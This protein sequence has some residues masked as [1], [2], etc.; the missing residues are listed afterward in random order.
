MIPEDLEPYRAEDIAR[1]LGCSKRTVYRA[2]QD[3]EIPGAFY[4]GRLLL[5]RRAEVLAWLGHAGTTSGSE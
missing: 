1:V 2:T 3:G 5:F 4:V